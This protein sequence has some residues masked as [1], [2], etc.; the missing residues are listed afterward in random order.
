MG[1]GRAIDGWEVTRFTWVIQVSVESDEGLAGE[2]ESQQLVGACWNMV[3]K[4]D[5]G[6]FGTLGESPK[7]VIGQTFPCP[8]VVES[9]L[10]VA[11]PFV[12]SSFLLQY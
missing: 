1:P 7:R 5:V 11:M 10:L 4:T 8:W 6:P 12:T 3:R 2:E 9:L